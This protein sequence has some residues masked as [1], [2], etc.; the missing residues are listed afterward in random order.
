MRQRELHDAA[1][2]VHEGLRG[3][4]GPAGPDKRAEPARDRRGSRDRPVDADSMDQPKPGPANRCAAPLR[5]GR[6]RGRVEA[7]AA[8]KRDPPP[9]AGHPQAGHGFSLGREVGEVRA[10]RCGEGGVPHA[11]S[12]PRSWRQPERLLCLE[13]AWPAA[14]STRCCSSMAIRPLRCPMAPVAACG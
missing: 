13:A 2:T 8:G 6:R 9:G 3:R 1:E 10:R 7:A 5:T 14:A 11:S 12:L 4:G